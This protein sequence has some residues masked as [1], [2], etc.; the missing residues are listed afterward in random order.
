MS[1]PPPPQDPSQPG[2][3]G[4]GFG[5]PQGFGPPAPAGPPAPVGPPAGGYGY[6]GPP[7]P[8]PGHGPGGFGPGVPGGPGPYP[9]PPPP[10]PGAGGGNGPKVAAIVIAAV[11][12]AALIVGGVLLLGGGGGKDN[13]ADDAPSTTPSATEKAE[14]SQETEEPTWDSSDPATAIPDPRESSGPS[15]TPRDP[16]PFV[17]L[18]PGTCFDH[19]ALSSAVSKVEERPCTS[20]HNGEVISNP[21]LTG[22]FATEQEIQEQVLKLCKQDAAVRLKKMPQDGTLYYFYAIY[23]SLPTYKYR[24]KDTISCSLTLSNSRDGKK[25]TGPLPGN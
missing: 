6:P 5:P 23:P 16:V 21:K 13:K 8:P 3:G 15:G 12:A 24:S 17:V 10:P 19:P 2:A 4:G 11:L 14:E 22:D 7:G 1:F 18:K 20:P 9:P 25:L